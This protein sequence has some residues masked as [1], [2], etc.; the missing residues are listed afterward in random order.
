MICDPASGLGRQSNRT[1]FTGFVFIFTNIANSVPESIPKLIVSYL[2][3][4]TRIARPSR[5]K[6]ALPIQ[7][8]TQGV[9]VSL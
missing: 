2:T 5:P 7:A 8:E 1:L 9:R 3:Q 4:R 6:K